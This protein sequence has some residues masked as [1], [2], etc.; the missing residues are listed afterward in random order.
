MEVVQVPWPGGDQLRRD[1]AALNA[2]RLLVVNNGSAPPMVSD[3]LEDWVRLPAT[4]EDIEARARTLARRAEEINFPSIDEDGVL[5]YDGYQVPLPPVEARLAEHL[6]R[7]MGA[8]ASRNDLAR[9]GWPGGM[10]TRNA[11]DVRILRLRRRVEPRG[12]LIRTVRHRG[13]LMEAAPKV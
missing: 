12:L 4:D 13:Y 6:V 2:P 8:V 11:L 10:P 3:P 9:A 7:R 5:S 1:L